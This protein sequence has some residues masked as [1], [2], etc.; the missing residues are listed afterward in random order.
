MGREIGGTN[1]TSL[2]V[3]GCFTCHMVHHAS[4]DVYYYQGIIHTYLV[5]V[6]VSTQPLC[7]CATPQRWGRIMD[8]ILLCRCLVFKLDGLAKET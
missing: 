4:P 6:K 2:D 1:K 5:N 3:P 8:K 7:N